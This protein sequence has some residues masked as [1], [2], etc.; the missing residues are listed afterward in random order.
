MYNAPESKLSLSIQY[1]QIWSVLG[2]TEVYTNMVGIGR[3]GSYGGKPLKIA[4]NE[5]KFI[6]IFVY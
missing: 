2:D 1:T 4:L 5:A 6:F 3:Y